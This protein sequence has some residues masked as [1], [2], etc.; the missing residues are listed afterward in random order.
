MDF[1]G[2]WVGFKRGGDLVGFG[3]VLRGG[4]GDLVGFGW[5]LGGF[6]FGFF[7]GFQKALGELEDPKVVCEFVSLLVCW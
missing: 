4:G 5:V 7:G 3:W 1:R 6:L 2:V